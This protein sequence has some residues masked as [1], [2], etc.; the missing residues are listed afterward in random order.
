MAAGWVSQR[1]VE[2]VSSRAEQTDSS[3]VVH[4]DVYLVELGVVQTECTKVAQLAVKSAE[5]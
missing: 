3:W 4:W 5:C 1:A 2:K